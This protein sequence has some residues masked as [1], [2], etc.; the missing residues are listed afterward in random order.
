MPSIT[1][2]GTVVSSE[3]TNG[4]S[5]FFLADQAKASAS[6]LSSLA[7]FDPGAM[8]TL[9]TSIA[10]GASYATLTTGCS[11]QY[12]TGSWTDANSAGIFRVPDGT[13]EWVELGI[14]AE[15]GHST[16]GGDSIIG[17]VD[18]TVSSNPNSQTF[19]TVVIGDLVPTDSPYETMGVGHTAV[20]VSSGDIFGWSFYSSG[21][22]PYAASEQSSV[23]CFTIRGLK[24]A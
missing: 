22:N 20:K 23:S 15:V 14:T 12:D 21:A 6:L 18:P 19:P 16:N 9:P 24:R 3:V 8:I 2:L 11:V 7:A 13:W 17:I 10:I 1:D 5:M 4:N